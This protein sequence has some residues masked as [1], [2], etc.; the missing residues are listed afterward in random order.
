MK[1]GCYEVIGLHRTD[2]GRVQLSALSGC[3]N[4]MTDERMGINEKVLENVCRSW[5]C[6]MYSVILSLNF[7]HFWYAL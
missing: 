4:Q 7:P 5:I 1:T 2:S 3:P 6:R